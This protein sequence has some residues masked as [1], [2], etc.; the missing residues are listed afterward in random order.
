[1]EQR[2]SNLPGRPQRALQS[3]GTRILSSVRRVLFV[4]MVRILLLHRQDA[5]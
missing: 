5:L 4:S 2:L 1:M 3:L